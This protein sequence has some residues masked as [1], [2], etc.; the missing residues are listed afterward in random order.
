[1]P[2][3]TVLMPVYNSEKYLR[4]AIDSIL[5][6][7]FNDFELLI[8]NDASTD[9]SKNIIL[10]YKDQRIRYYEN[11]KNLGVAKTLNR[12]LRLACGDYIA[13]MD[14][15][16]IS[17]PFRLK[18]QIDFM[19]RNP[20]IVVCG[21]WVRAFKETD[22]AVWCTPADYETI[23]STMLFHSAIY[24]PTVMTRAKVLKRHE[25]FYSSTFDGSEDYEF[26]VRIADHFKIVNLQEV[27]LRHR[28]HSNHRDN[29]V[30]DGNSLK[31]SDIV[32]HM[33]LKR[34]S[35]A[36]TEKEF[37]IHRA[38][39]LGDLR[40]EKEFV[41][42]T[43]AWFRKLMK[44]NKRKKIYTDSSFGKLLIEKW[45]S[46]CSN[47]MLLGPWMWAKFWRSSVNKQAHLPMVQKMSFVF[48]WIKKW[49]NNTWNRK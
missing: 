47:A 43:E 34:L 21:G 46:V 27:L 36:P 45:F 22:S 24:H 16:D 11:N 35:I 49:Q 3:I 6:Q 18:R 37:E 39:S 29:S 40:A 5:N 2:K 25:L 38:I 23:K 10:S 14:A 48:R 9:N 30:R 19:D 17:V 31:Q 8:I 20:E 41:E 1:M 26:W 4:E 42:A 44:H 32:R 15:D 12:G 33:Q 28:I 7:T 13:R